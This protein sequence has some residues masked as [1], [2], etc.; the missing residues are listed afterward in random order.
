M[1]AAVGL[2]NIWRFPFIAGS[3]GG[4]AFLIAYLVAMAA[5]AMPIAAVELAAGRS[6]RGGIVAALTGAGRWA[7]PVGA[8]I[9][10]ASVIVVSYYLVVTGWT[11]GYAAHTPGGALP[12]FAEFT[13]G[14][15][16]LVW[17]A[18]AGAVGFVVVARGLAGGIELVAKV[19]T[20]LL[21]MLLLGLAIYATTLDSFSDAAEFFLVPDMDQ[22][23]EPGTWVAAVGQVFFSVGVGMGVLV[24]YGA[25]VDEQ[26]NLALSSVGIALA[27]AGIA[28]T[29]G[30]V[31]FPLA[32]SIGESPQAGPELAFNS[33]PEAFRRLGTAG[34]IIAPLFYISLF[35]AALTSAIALLEVGVIALRDLLGLTRARA[36]LLLVVPVVII[37]SASALSYAS[38]ELT[39]AGE[40]VLDQLD[41]LVGDFGLPLG[42]LATA[43]V[44]GWWRPELITR[45]LSRPAIAGRGAVVAAR[46][47][48]PVAII[49]TLLA[50]AA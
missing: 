6:S 36:A 14:Y 17:F 39:I 44:V 4:G 19:L 9:A 42:V 15:A 11:L 40:P 21:V 33:L 3:N 48:I 49:A 8:A 38:P 27:D 20:P 46:W 25:Y 23:L 29:A 47:V 12:A 24:T 34:T 7:R 22:L 1:G 26:E 45:N 18:I 16:S 30:L 35:A 2:G 10:L 31:V 13:D 41:A 32:F 43:L 50:Q 37:G 28:F 5:L